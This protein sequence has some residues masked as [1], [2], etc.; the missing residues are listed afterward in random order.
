MDSDSAY[1]PNGDYLQ[2]S[3]YGWHTPV[4][5]LPYANE[6]A[7]PYGDYGPPMVKSEYDDCGGVDGV[8]GDG[9]GGLSGAGSC[10]SSGLEQDAAETKKGLYKS[11]IYVL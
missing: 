1:K 9:G 11:I 7:Y 8:Q 10:S 6:A 3:P 5:D 4:Q 2:L